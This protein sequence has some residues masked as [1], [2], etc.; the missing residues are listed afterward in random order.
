VQTVQFLKLDI[1]QKYIDKDCNSGLTYMADCIDYDGNPYS[2]FLSE[3]LSAE[4]NDIFKQI[5]LIPGE[6]GANLK[7]EYLGLFPIVANDRG[8]FTV[9]IDLV[10][11]KLNHNPNPE[12]SESGCSAEFGSS[13]IKNEF[14]VTCRLLHASCQPA[15]VFS[16]VWTFEP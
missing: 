13:T 14:F 10:S 2:V 6:E 16:S 11:P 7:K 1:N 8:L 4:L 3:E 15:C 9:S 5:M 12:F